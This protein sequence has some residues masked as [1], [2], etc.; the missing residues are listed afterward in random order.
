MKHV[1]VN[2]ID[3]IMIEIISNQIYMKMAGFDQ[4]LIEQSGICKSFGEGNG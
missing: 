3:Y 2:T 1:F 4:A